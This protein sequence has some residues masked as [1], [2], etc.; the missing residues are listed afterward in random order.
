MYCWGPFQNASPVIAAIIARVNMQTNFP[1]DVT[2]LKIFIT[3]KNSSRTLIPKEAKAYPILG[4]SG[5]KENNLS[6]YV[7]GGFTIYC[8]TGCLLK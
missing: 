2:M 7:E 3:D 6:R 5:S 8:Y 1:G 4:E